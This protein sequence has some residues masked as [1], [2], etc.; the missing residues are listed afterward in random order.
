M[1]FGVIGI[2]ITITE[3]TCSSRILTK[4]LL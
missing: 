3:P 4:F 2:R 1:G